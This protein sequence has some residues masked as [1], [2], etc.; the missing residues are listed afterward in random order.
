MDALT[1]QSA[2]LGESV[3][4]WSGLQ[5]AASSGRLRMEP[6]VAEQ[7]AKH[8]ED[9]KHKLD[10]HYADAQQ[11]QLGEGLRAPSLLTARAVARRFRC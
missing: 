8:C 2:A 3:G 6:G 5:Q 10:G 1:A 7:C 4:A 11:L 9:L